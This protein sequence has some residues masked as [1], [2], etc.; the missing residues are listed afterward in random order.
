M[1]IWKAAPPE[2]PAPPPIRPVES[3][4]GK[5]V[6]LIGVGGI[7]MSAIAR[8]LQSMGCLVSGCDAAHSEITD[9]LARDGVDIFIGHSPSH[10]VEGEDANPKADMVIISAAVRDTNPELRSARQADIAVLKYAQALGWLTRGRDVIAVAG[11]HGKTTTSSMIAFAHNRAGLNPSMVIGGMVP[12]LGGNSCT[13]AGGPFVVEACEFDR[14]FLNLTPKAAVIAN[15]DRDHLD[16]Y[17]GGIEELIEAF[18][19]FAGQVADDGLVVVNGDDPHAVRAGKRATARVQT[20]GEGT[21]CDWRISDCARADGVT[22]FRVHHGARNL[23]VFQ[24]SIPGFYNV[25]NAMACIAICEHFGVNRQDVREALL[26]FAGAKRRFDRLGEAGGVTVVDDYGHHPT[27]VRVTLEAARNEFP[28]RR[29]WCVFQPHQYSR[30]RMLL[31]DFGRAFGSA[32]RVIVPD[33][34]AARDNASDRA[35]VHS[36]DLVRQLRLNGVEAEYGSE[37]PDTL[38]RLLDVVQRGDVV[39]TMGAGP[40]DGVARDL[41][42]GLRKREEAKETADGLVLRV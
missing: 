8:L 22:R 18:G 1:P 11:S 37:L 5:H 4:A 23:G 41:L 19:S 39:M 38:Q 26:E 35:S 6:H 3:L 27:E 16:Y 34:H 40:V 20:F 25:R 7:G 17:R 12:Q 36:R 31:E 14:S 10:V 33:I 13:G 32:D 28:L 21:H 29:V 42:A 30:T 15:V 2:L 24:L 9:A